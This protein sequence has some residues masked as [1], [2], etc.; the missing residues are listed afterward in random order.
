MASEERTDEDKIIEILKIEGMVRQYEDLD[1]LP[2]RQSLYEEEDQPPLYD[3]FIAPQ[4][5]W[6]RPQEIDP[7]CQYFADDYVSPRVSAGTLPDE[8]FASTLMAVCSFQGYDLL[9]TIIASRPDDF[10]IYGV[11]SC[12]FY[13]EGEWVEVITDT[14]LPCVRNELTLQQTPAYSK[15]PNS[16]EMWVALLEKAYAKAVGSYEAIQKIKLHETLLHLTGGSIQ[17]YFTADGE[18]VTPL[19]ATVLNIF[20]EEDVLVMARP[21]QDNEEENMGMEAGLADVPNL[22]GEDGDRPTTPPVASPS[23]SGPSSPDRRKEKSPDANFRSNRTYVLA[24]Y[25]D[26]ATFHLVCVFDAW[27]DVNWSGAWC[28]D[29]GK[30]DDFPELLHAAEADTRTNWT[31]DDL[32]SGYLWMSLE[33]FKA[34]FCEVTACKLF[35]NEKFKYYR[36]L[37][38][39]SP[40][41]ERISGPLST[42]QDKHA[43]IKQANEARVA[44]SMNSTAAYSIDADASWFNNPQTRIFAKEKATV[45]ISVVPITGDGEAAPTPSIN[46]AVTAD[47]AN[48]SHIWDFATAKIISNAELS[49]GL[50]LAKGQESSI[51]HLDMEPDMIYHIIP[52]CAKK[53]SYGPFVVRIFSPNFVNVER[54]PPV[55]RTVLES[56]WKRTTNQDTAGGPPTLVDVTA[57]TGFRA[58][59][60]WSQNPQFHVNLI[61]KFSRK[62]VHLKLVLRRKDKPAKTAKGSAPETI[63]FV[64]CKADCLEDLQPL[65]KKG[66]GPRQ[67]ALGEVIPSKE[68]SLRRKKVDRSEV[69]PTQASRE[70]GKTILRRTAPPKDAFALVTTGTSRTEATAYFPLLPRS[71]CANGLLVVPSLAYVGNKGNFALEVYSS[72]PVD[73]TE[74]PE[75]FMKSVASDWTEI[76]CGGSHICEMWKKNPRFIMKLLSNDVSRQPVKMRIT[77]SRYG[78]GWDHKCRADAVGNMIG[79]YIFR[80]NMGQQELVY[81]GNFVPDKEVSTDSDFQLEPLD[82]NEDYIILASTFAEGKQG[83]FVLNIMADCEVSLTKGDAGR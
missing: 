34:L 42:V 15:S 16:S 20:Q 7:T 46:V 64:V 72:E 75:Q 82:E 54:M 33:D 83:A 49:R 81:E 37:D 66:G 79:F 65:R 23:A 44:S 40:P 1:F 8:T 80:T 11:I 14:R 3:E 74:M 5:V 22:D 4:M 25:L 62:D 17:Q 52:S 30:W 39:W 26:V 59:S 68:S 57:K 71:W 13:V 55:R 29:S 35:P 38:E 24:S 69:A 45:S 73:V 28:N 67:N 27:R 36:M 77:L 41:E 32:D 63:S 61:D 10:K 43:T 6:C 18:G 50:P 47:T 2:V 76:L 58:N 78:D 48:Q 19:W 12:R 31:R 60:K 53:T 56:S 51:W 70:S 21:N 9:E